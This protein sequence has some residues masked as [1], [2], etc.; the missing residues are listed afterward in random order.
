MM[1]IQY[2]DYRFVMIISDTLLSIDIIIYN[3]IAG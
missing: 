2:N 1:S 3:I